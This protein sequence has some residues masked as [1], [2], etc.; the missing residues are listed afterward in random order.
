M[1]II[2]NLRHNSIA[3]VAIT[4]ITMTFLPISKAVYADNEAKLEKADTQSDPEKILDFFVFNKKTKEPIA[5]TELYIR[6]N[7][8][9]RSDKT[10]EYGRC[11]II[12]DAEQLTYVRIKA[13][14]EG[15]VPMQVMW[16]LAEARV[17]P[18]DKYTLYLEPGTS[19][20]GIIQNEQGK[21]IQ[22]VTINLLVPGGDE[23]E[24]V[25]IWDHQEKTDANGQWRCDIMPKKLDDVLIRLSHPDYIDDEAYG[26]TPKPSIEKLRDMTG[27]MVMKK[28]LTL[29]GRVLDLNGQPI[30]EASVMQGSDRFG[31]HYSSTKTDSNG[32]FIFKNARPGE[33]ILTVQA[34]GYCPDLKHITVYEGMPSIEFRLEPGHMIRGR[35]VDSENNPIEGAS[36]TADTWRGHRTLNWRVD[37][38]NEGRFQW[39]D[40]PADEVLIDMG[41]RR[42]MS[43]RNH[44]MTA[45]D[46]EYVITMHPE[47]KVR[48]KVVDT[49]T[50]EPIA[51]LKALPGIDWGRNQPV[52]WQRSDAKTFTQGYYE[53]TFDSSYPAHL[54]RIEAEGYKPGIS[55]RFKD[56]EG[57]VHYD[58]KLEKGTGPTGIVQFPDG[59][60]VSGAEVIL[61]TPSQGA[62]IRNGRNDQKR[63]SQFVE[64]KEDGRFSF[65]AQ[66]DIYSIVVLHDKGYAEVSSEKL[67]AS[68]VVTLQPWGR[69]EGKLLIGKEPGENETVGVWFKTPYEPNA[70]RIYHDCR[71]ITDNNGHFVFKR[72]PPG[73]GRVGREIRTS[74]NSYTISHSIPVEIKPTETI[75]VV[76]GGTGRPIVGKIVAPAD[77]KEPIN[78]AYGHNRLSLKVPKFPL[79]FF[80]RKLQQKQRRSYAVKIEHDG[81]FRVEDVPAGKY[82]LRISVYEPPTARQYGHG[83]L[84]GSGIYDF[85]VPEMPGGRSDE[86]LDIGT[87]QMKIHQHLKVNDIAPLFELQ[88]MDGK[89]LKLADYKGKVVLL[90]FGAT[91]CGPCIAEMPKLKE[92]YEEFGKDERF[93]MIGLSLDKNIE[94]L[95][96]YVI[97]ND[98]KWPH[99]F[100]GGG[101]DSTVTKDYCIRAIPAKFLIGPD[102]KIISKNRNVEQLK[103]E[104][105]KAL[106]NLSNKQ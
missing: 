60:A 94:T 86:P 58:F 98:L 78:W 8:K 35:I 62:Y 29:R 103:L 104:A 52:H 93:V 92:L 19:I 63:D 9:G 51:E 97:K 31:S 69:V 57:Q 79:L 10:D 44:G 61:C 68:S 25:A 100:I 70:P 38:N 81:S 28:G 16:R 5:G 59:K 85:K 73:E 72:I 105:A 20:G 42:F 30:T 64:T 50:G 99:C 6:I 39:N 75:N 43:V 71:A 7:R 40:A 65:P 47:L 45:S 96:G 13:Q 76:I 56:D 106:R 55:R 3:P 48:G 54:I 36:V 83:E 17:K 66:I 89:D 21:P 101:F 77:Y 102:G 15:F 26:M 87:L 24:R 22:G 80:M 82:R 4:F 74:Y 95:K 46:K 41:K 1:K 23:L 18:P 34:S 90:D 84:I 49:E 11:R 37:T 14:K 33:M 32:Q 88:T 67:T 91:W 12:L 2:R 27:V 53:I